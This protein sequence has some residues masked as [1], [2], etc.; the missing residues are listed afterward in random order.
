MARER[1]LLETLLRKAFPELRTEIQ[2][3]SETSDITTNEL[4]KAYT[5]LRENRVVQDAVNLLSPPGILRDSIAYPIYFQKQERE[6]RFTVDWVQG[7]D[8]FIGHIQMAD[9]KGQYKTQVR[10]YGLR[11]VE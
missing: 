5:Y 1:V 4:I 10:M 9:D 11:I 2:T 7:Q 8:V 3:L 6:M